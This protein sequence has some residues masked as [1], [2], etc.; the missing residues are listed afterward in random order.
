[1]RGF[2]AA[3][4]ALLGLLFAWTPLAQRID[5]ALLDTE[6]SFLRQFHPKDAPDDIIVVGVDDA[7]FKAIQE[8]LGMWHE[9]LGRALEKIAAAKPRA[10]GLDVTLPDRSYDGMRA[11]LDRALLAGLVAARDNGAVVAALTI[12]SRTQS[13]RPIHLPFLAV[14][15]EERLGI[16]LFGRDAD[17]VTRRFSLAIPTDDAAFPTLVGRLCRALQKKCADGHIDFAL[18]AP[19]RYVPLHEVLK[20]EDKEYLGKLFRDRIVMIGE[21]QRFSDRISVPV[22]LAGW[23][24]AK[25]DSPGVVVHAA[26]LRTALHGNPA[27]DAGKPFTVVLV[28]AT[29]LLV[30]MRNWRL[31]FVAAAVAA[32]LLIAGATYAL[33]SGHAIAVA[34]ALFTLALAWI[35]RPAYEAWRERRERERLRAGFGG[36]VSP[37][38]LRAILKGDIKPGR[39]GEKRELA[40]LFADLRGSTAMAAHSTPEEAMALL[41]RFHQVI[42][43]A[44][45]RHDG[46]LDNIRGD[47][48]MAV[49]GAPKPLPNPVKSAWAA[50]QEM[51]RGLDRLNA[52]LAKEGKP[53]LTM[54]AGV[55]YGEAVVGHVGARDRFN[56]TAVGDAVNIAARLQDEAKRRGV[57]VLLSGPA[58]ERLEDA[59]LEP[60]GSMEIEGHD[61]VEAWG[62][63]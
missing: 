57:R 37:S 15:R 53:A 8:P 22:N 52:E 25:R 23:E 14:L 7:T 28:S 32:A 24:T 10:I 30:F 48:A 2:A 12:D 63:R 39:L 20:S 17:G 54:V 36:F 38:V 11:G 62:W 34:A 35:S 31:A 44:V 33:H 49:F 26:A 59:A 5:L 1:M 3:A 58:R 29:A 51:F 46:M 4:L 6:F 9:P 50:T 47:G 19:F 43:N 60:L 45:H 16:S 13:A 40:F 21:T 18:G 55:A 41:N 56:Y 27:D 61:P 42:A